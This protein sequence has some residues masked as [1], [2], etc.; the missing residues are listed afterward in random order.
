M[1]QYVTVTL[2]NGTRVTEEI[3]NPDRVRWD[4]TAARQ[5]WPSFSD[6][7]FL[8]M[9][10]LSFA[11]LKRTGQYTGTWEEFRDTDCADIEMTDAE[12]NALDEDDL[13]GAT[14]KKVMPID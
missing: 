14:E 7:A 8:G 13:D 11:A 10:F 2:D 5:G 9:T 6:A 12:G 1:A 3:R 4:M